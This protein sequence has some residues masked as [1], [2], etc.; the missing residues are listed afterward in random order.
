MVIRKMNSAGAADNDG[1]SPRFT[2]WC[3]EPLVAVLP[4]AFTQ[5]LHDPTLMPADWKNTTM[6]PILRAQKDPRKLNSNRPICIYSPLSRILEGVVAK[7]LAT[8]VA[9]R[10]HG[11]QYGFRAGFSPLDDLGSVVGPALMVCDT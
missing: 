4:P 8:V 2:Q 6:V 9:P 5:I 1:L 3:L 7:R 11:Q 10:L